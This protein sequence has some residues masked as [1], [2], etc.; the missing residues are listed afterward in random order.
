MTEILKFTEEDA[1]KNLKLRQNQI[2]AEKASKKPDQAK[3]EKLTREQT[4][5]AITADL[6]FNNQ[7]FRREMLRVSPN[8][9]KGMAEYI[10]ALGKKSG[11]T[12]MDLHKEARQKEQV[13]LQG[14]LDSMY[15]KRLEAAD[16]PAKL[17]SSFKGFALL[18]QAC[19]VDTTNF[20]AEC[21]RMIAQ[22]YAKVP[23]KDINR[24][25]TQPSFTVDYK[26]AEG[27]AQTA[28]D[29]GVK[30]ADKLS[31]ESER[32]VG[33][34]A[35]SA[36]SLIDSQSP[37]TAQPEKST[38]TSTK[39]TVTVGGVT[40]AMEELL[41]ESKLLTASNSAAVKKDMGAALGAAATSDGDGKTVS[42]KDKKAMEYNVAEVLEKH[43]LDSKGAATL[44][45]QAIEKAMG[46]EF[47]YN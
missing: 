34:A 35:D 14:E 37:K 15:Q 42:D 27:M 7:D 43:H 47:N 9:Q 19:G 36:A 23:S 29:S 31:N 25:I 5:Y 8:L 10:Q 13:S 24:L 6:V 3:I 32:S 26:Q 46:R 16:G 41:A 30:L 1:L 2:N 11:D 21:D 44:T 39:K 12:F 40:T 4:Q 22:E 28:T 17:L 33:I 20:V 38:T 45:R 18:L